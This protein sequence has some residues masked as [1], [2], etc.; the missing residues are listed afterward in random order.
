MKA[1]LFF[2]L[3]A[4]PVFAQ[5]Q[6]VETAVAPG[7]GAD[8]VKFEVQTDKHQHP[9]TRP[10]AGKALVYFIEDDTEFTGFQRPTTRAG[11]DGQWVGATHGDSY[12]YFSVDPGEH[13]VCA[14]WQTTAM[15]RDHQVAAAHFTAEAGG[16]YCFRAKNMSG[17]VRGDVPRPR[18]IFL[19][20]LDS[21]EGLV[22]ASKSS[23][24]IS[25][26]KK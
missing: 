8:N 21:D 10:A 25:H 6:P 11:L 24:S 22:L 15:V 23:Y 26:P 13:H 5:D 19:K 3:L 16:V 2:L 14:S 17:Y 7:C 18:G 4:S 1:A 20:Q 12:F 9:A